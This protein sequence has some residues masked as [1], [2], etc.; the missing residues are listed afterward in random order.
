MCTY[1]FLPQHKRTNWN[2]S[3]RWIVHCFKDRELM[4]ALSSAADSTA[5]FALFCWKLPHSVKRR[6]YRSPP[7][8][9]GGFLPDNLEITNKCKLQDILRDTF[10]NHTLVLIQ[11]EETVLLQVTT[12]SQDG[13]QSI[14]EGFPYHQKQKH[15]KVQ[16]DN[17]EV[18][19]D[20]R[21]GLNYKST[22]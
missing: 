7:Q 19:E 11:H 3:K 4:L 2:E 13:Q 8:G 14:M 21:E 10:K 17:M 9:P 22:S 12:T 1:R 16:K 15:L 18:K 20:L 6:G 5:W